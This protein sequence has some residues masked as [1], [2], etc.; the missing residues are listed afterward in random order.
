MP[1][2]VRACSRST[3]TPNERQPFMRI[4]SVAVLPTATVVVWI[5]VVALSHAAIPTFWH[6]S[7]PGRVSQG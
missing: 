6:V 2:P 3:S 7:H 4:P 5:V 1:S